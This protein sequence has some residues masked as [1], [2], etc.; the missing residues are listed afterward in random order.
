MK[1]LL[2][3]IFISVVI[4]LTGALH[5]SE[6]QKGTCG[7]L[8]NA[9]PFYRTYNAAAVDHYYT[10]SVS[11]VNQFD[12]QW[13]LQ[14]VAAFVFVDQEDST[15][16]LYHLYNGN[17]VDN[18]YTTSMTEVEAALKIGY[19]N[20]TTDVD[21]MTYIYPTQICGSTPLYRL[22]SASGTDNF[23]TTSESER[24]EVI[25]NNGYADVEIAGYVLP[26]T[27]TALMLDYLSSVDF[28]SSFIVEL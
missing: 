25:A 7:D 14:Q 27:P 23:Y 5:I 13:A 18:F 26:P 10:A 15:V 8:G 22:Y 9:V 6:P 17:V 4:R 24:L 2:S 16:P 21:P 3:A 12:S 19:Q 11:R 28:E 20:V 1:Y